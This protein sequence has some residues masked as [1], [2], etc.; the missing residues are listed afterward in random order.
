MQRAPSQRWTS[1]ASKAK[2]DDWS[3]EDEFNEDDEIVEQEEEQ[4]AVGG[5]VSDSEVE[6]EVFSKKGPLKEGSNGTYTV[7]SDK[8][9][10]GTWKPEL[11]P[12]LTNDPVDPKQ[13]IPAE[14]KGTRD[15][16]F[17]EP[18]VSLVGATAT[19]EA[20][21]GPRTQLMAESKA[22]PPLNEVKSDWESDLKTREPKIL[23][24]KKPITERENTI[25]TVEV[26]QFVSEP[27][28]DK[29][30]PDQETS[31]DSIEQYQQ[32]AEREHRERQQNLEK[33]E[34]LY[35]SISNDLG[36][37][38]ESI[39]FTKA[40]KEPGSRLDKNF[41]DLFDDFENL[42][43][44]A[45]GT[46]K[47]AATPSQVPAST[48]LPLEVHH[49]QIE[50][51]PSFSGTSKQEEDD[52]GPRPRSTWASLDLKPLVEESDSD[53][54][55]PLDEELP[56][57]KDASI[58]AAGPRQPLMASPNLRNTESTRLNDS[59]TQS[60]NIAEGGAWGPNPNTL[61][62]SYESDSY[63]DS[64]ADSA[65]F[66]A[67]AEKQI[68]TTQ[69]GNASDA[70]SIQEYP[71]DTSQITEEKVFGD[72]FPSNSLE[73]DQI[74]TDDND[75][76]RTSIYRN[77]FLDRTNRVHDEFDAL[78]LPPVAVAA[79]QNQV[80]KA[81][82][83][84]GS[85]L[86]DEEPSVPGLSYAREYLQ[87]DDKEGEEEEE[88]EEERHAFK[89][90]T[91]LWGTSYVNESKAQ[92]DVI[93]GKIEQE[94]DQMFLD[95]S[96]ES[97]SVVDT[98][99]PLTKQKIETAASDEASENTESQSKSF[100]EVLAGLVQTQLGPSSKDTQRKRALELISILQENLPGVERNMNSITRDVN[101]TTTTPL[102]PAIASFGDSGHEE[103]STPVRPISTI[104][105]NEFSY[106]TPKKDT[107]PAVPPKDPTV[108][109]P[110]QHK[111]LGHGIGK[112]GTH[113]GELVHEMLRKVRKDEYLHDSGLQIWLEATLKSSSTVPMLSAVEIG[114]NTKA[115]YSVVLQ[116]SV[117]SNYNPSSGRRMSLNSKINIGSHRFLKGTKNVNKNVK[118]KIEE[119]F[120]RGLFK[121][122]K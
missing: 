33:M 89:T 49:E 95:S 17:N 10:V 54:E 110:R 111:P 50:I 15:N 36:E 75:E 70:K 108:F 51:D 79:A 112:P 62:Q 96:E 28:S 90:G 78:A 8:P 61:E 37:G 41:D 5:H 18:L 14:L 55:E 98:A 84:L 101:N 45:N 107:S 86:D 74:F 85:V 122:K 102:E 73:E 97:H 59:G 65:S 68:R 100:E 12:K 25:P 56:V 4:E 115:A 19:F 46:P 24:E 23:A 22:K 114:P 94:K 116:Q 104:D 20:K 81:E 99:K 29:D 26:T 48:K 64:I 60:Q 57:S 1:G 16:S 71:G 120:A 43:F 83:V 91:G 47:T 80:T 119:G 7:E 63:E 27:T 88:E 34:E 113:T 11:T 93:N 117:N 82:D 105:T 53:T 92:S 3:D 2:Y 106:D 31:L 21:D 6:Q 66:E 121:R 44:S 39:G 103:V 109:S 87:M 42:T 72:S 118:G 58:A 13:Q 32:K 30:S 38:P 69:K 9:S 77:D 40:E 67:L 76:F 52:Y 35:R